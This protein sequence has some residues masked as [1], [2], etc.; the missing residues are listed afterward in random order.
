MADYGIDAY[1]LRP[2]PQRDGFMQ[3]MDMGLALRQQ[4]FREAMEVQKLQMDAQVQELQMRQ[5]EGQIKARHYENLLAADEI[6]DAGNFG[7]WAKSVQAGKPIDYTPKTKRGMEMKEMF[8]LQNDTLAAERSARLAMQSAYSEVIKEEPW[9]A[10]TIGQYKPYSPEWS[11]AVQQ[12]MDLVEKKRETIRERQLRVQS[13][14]IEQRQVAVENIRA[15]VRREIEQER[16]K[17]REKGML[18]DDLTDAQKL[19]FD[20]MM[21]GLNTKLSDGQISKDD[22][23]LYVDA[24]RDELGIRKNFGGGVTADPLGLFK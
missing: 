11:D 3:G 4:K 22:Y 2:A 14:L 10:A 9:M 18:M 21:T 1:W 17:L 15:N 20:K 6:A 13:G 24:L 8:T 23:D 19:Q 5:I 12:G 16:M 7:L